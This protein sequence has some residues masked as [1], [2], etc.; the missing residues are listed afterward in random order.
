MDRRHF[1]E[2]LAAGLVVGGSILPAFQSLAG[3]LFV[4]VQKD[5]EGLT[6]LRRFFA[7]AIVSFPPKIDVES[8]RLEIDGAVS[9]P[10]AV[11]YDELHQWPQR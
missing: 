3:P 10:L 6:P 1:L 8:E 9:T 4:P 2:T 5:E 11:G 7:V